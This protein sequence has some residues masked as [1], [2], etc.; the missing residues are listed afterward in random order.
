MALPKTPSF[1][2]DGKTALIT[3]ASS[4]IGRAAAVALAEA[5]A[6][7]TV[8]ARRSDALDQLVA[9]LQD[10]G[11]SAG[12]QVMDVANI[13]ETQQLVSG[14]GPFDILLNSAGLARH[15]PAV[16]TNESDFDAV[17]DLNVKGA[18]FLSQAV[19]KGLI[20]AG[21][22]GSLMNISSQMPPTCA[23][24]DEIFINDP[25]RPAAIN[26]FATAWVRK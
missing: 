25:L 23:I 22:S 21:R 16:D 14:L 1:R 3:G 24:W 17:S 6:H 13:P 11:H 12:A 8:A 7:V 19:A 4:G 26:P 15:S 10:A 5:G 9:E 20:A 18:Y 2:L